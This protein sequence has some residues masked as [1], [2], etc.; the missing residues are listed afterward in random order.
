M[1]CEKGIGTDNPNIDKNKYLVPMDLTVGK[2]L[3]VIR[4]K[5][6]LQNYEALFLMIDNTIPPSTSNFK[7]LYDRRKDTDG[8]F[9]MTYTKENVF[10]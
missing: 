9:Y 2:F 5:I 4:K 10:G 8:Y 7:E 6:K 3:V 1:I